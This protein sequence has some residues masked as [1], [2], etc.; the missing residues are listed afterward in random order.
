MDILYNIF[1]FFSVFAGCVIPYPKREF[2]TDDDQE[3]K[4]EN[5]SRQAQQNNVSSNKG[6]KCNFCN[7]FKCW[8]FLI[9]RNKYLSISLIHYIMTK[10]WKEFR[11]GSRE[12]GRNSW[13][14]IVNLNLYF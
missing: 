13:M 8:E 7:F 1:L 12:N 10:K 3:E 5:K 11:F 6:R 14:W 2:L 9:K 4:A